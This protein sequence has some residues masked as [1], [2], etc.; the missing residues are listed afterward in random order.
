M[1]RVMSHLRRMTPDDLD[2]VMAL[3]EA[4]FPSPWSR[5]MLTD[6]LGAARRHYVVLEGADGLAGYGGIMVSGDEGHVMTIA[7]DAD[8]RGRGFGSRIMVA[9][10]RAAVDMGATRMLLEVR[11]SSSA[12]RRL[13]RRFGFVPVGIRPR[14]YRD[15]DAI[16][17]WVDDA[18]TPAF[19]ERLER[20]ERSWH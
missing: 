11:P 5:R 1:A 6:E 9:L 10:L 19:A 13:Y 3:E 18:D 16:V 14:Y 7:V 20:M 17:M 8:H 12:A 2:A 15:E 4:T